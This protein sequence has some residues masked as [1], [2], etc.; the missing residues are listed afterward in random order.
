[1]ERVFRCRAV[2]TKAKIK[3][4]LN[5]KEDMCSVGP[6]VAHQLNFLIILTSSNFWILI[7]IKIWASRYLKEEIFGLVFKSLLIADAEDDFSVY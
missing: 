2:T 5:R 1:M 7:D 3:V 6:T 4:T